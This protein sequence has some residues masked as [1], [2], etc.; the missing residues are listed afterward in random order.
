TIAQRLTP[1]F[2]GAFTDD[3]HYGYGRFYAW[4]FQLAGASGSFFS[5]FYAKYTDDNVPGTTPE[6]T[7][8]LRGKLISQPQVFHYDDTSRFILAQASNH[9][10]YALSPTGEQLWNAQLPGPVLGEIHQL[11]DNSIVL[12]TAERL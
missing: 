11:S 1:P 10:L 9:I 2:R 5:S 8:N 3:D 4:S 6:W 7:F 12:T